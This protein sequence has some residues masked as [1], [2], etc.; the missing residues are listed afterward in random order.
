MEIG[1]L[2]LRLVLA[3]ILFTHAMQKLTGWFGGNGLTKQGE[4]FSSLGLRP[5]RPLV[6]AAGVAELTAAT[7]LVTG[8]LT[9]LGALLAAGTMAV[10]GMT[11]HMNSGRFWNVAGGGEYPYVLAACAGV[12]GF[13]GGGGFSVDHVLANAVGGWYEV[14]AHPPVWLGAAIVALAAVSTVPFVAI[15]RQNRA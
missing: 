6:A 1:L 10:A 7:L 3:T 15:L 2:I 8:F 14:L 13:T 5:G 9:P 12:L 4:V 11:M